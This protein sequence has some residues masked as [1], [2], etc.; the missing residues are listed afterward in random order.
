M[1]HFLVDQLRFSRRELVRCLDG[2][3]DEDA[4]Q[5]I[6]PMNCI[7]WIIGHLATQEQYFWVYAGQGR[8]I[9][10]E[11]YKLVATGQPATTP[12][13]D[14]MWNV[15][16]EITAAA[17]TYLDTL[18][19]GTMTTYLEAEGKQMRE[20]IGTMLLRNIHHIWFHIGE[21]HAIRQQLGHPDLP[22]FVGDMSGAGYRQ[23]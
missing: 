19:A 14:D 7:S 2:I 9:D 16:K 23:K 5:R 21:A 8:V 17:D 18:T 20:P 3:S 12:P 22:Q 13:L 4:R 1:T 6:M 15:W 11:L 10:R